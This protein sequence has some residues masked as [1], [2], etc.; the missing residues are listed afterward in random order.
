MPCAPSGS[1]RDKE[2]E[3]CMLKFQKS[4]LPPFDGPNNNIWVK[5]TNY[6]VH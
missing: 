6:E 3:E 4:H 1:N 5:G 2:E